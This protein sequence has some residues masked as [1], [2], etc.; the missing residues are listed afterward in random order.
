MGGAC[1][2]YVEEEKYLQSYDEETWKKLKTL[3]MYRRKWYNNIKMGVKFV[4]WESVD[5]VCLQ[6]M[7]EAFLNTALNLRVS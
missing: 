2:T 5:M 7:W 1:G 4:G 3:W 6:G